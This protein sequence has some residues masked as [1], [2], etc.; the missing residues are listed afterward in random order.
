MRLPA[1]TFAL[2]AAL[3]TPLA[4]RVVLAAPPAATTA[5]P[6][7]VVV[8][9]APASKQ[10]VAGLGAKLPDPWQLADDGPFR[11]ALANAGQRTAAGVALGNPQGKA[12]LAKK[13]QSAASDTGTGAV[14]FVRVTP[15]KGSRLVTLLLV[16]P[17][18][19]EPLLDTTAEVPASDDGTAIAGVLS[20]ALARAARPSAPS[21]SSSS[22]PPPPASDRPSANASPQ[23]APGD[24]A[25]STSTALGGADSSILVFSAG[26]GSGA[27]IFRY[28]DGLSPGLRT[29]DLAASPNLVLSA[30]VY[31]LARLSTPVVRGLGV[32]GGFQHALGVS[33]KTSTGTSVSTTWLRGE[34]GLRLR[35]SFGDEGRFILGLHGGI[36]KERFGF[37]GDPKLVDW[38]P[39]VDYLFWRAGFDGRLR[40]GPVAILAGASYLP[41][42]QSGALADRFRQTWF[43]AVEMGGGLAVPVVRVFEMRATAVYT[44]VFYA[45][46]PEPGDIYVAGGALDHLIR[47]QIL[48]TL[49]L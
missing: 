21:S 25:P 45:F 35:L 39:D 9:D 23:G 16:A 12:A 28:H 8:A 24:T 34:G 27:R 46:H 14:L 47:A 22:T 41:A 11:K 13:A 43:A 19:A 44:R 36:V 31:P 15:K 40:A 17:G 2:A 10:A 48:A 38:L 3:L 18:E 42:I 6:T 4:S 7:L 20:P 32:Y 1:L 5:R 30:E 49:L 37:K 29:Y 33:S 26:G